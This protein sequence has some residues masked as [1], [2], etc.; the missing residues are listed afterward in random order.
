VGDLL[1]AYKKF[2]PKARLMK[3][4]KG[5]S[6]IIPPLS[7]ADNFSLCIRLPVLGAALYCSTDNDSDAD[8]M[9]TDE[10]MEVIAN[11]M[12]AGLTE[13][14]LSNDY[15]TRARSAAASCVHATITL[16]RARGQGCPVIPLVTNVINPAIAS[17]IDMVSVKDC[18]N[19]LALVVSHRL[20]GT[21]L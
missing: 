19:L 6:N 16:G 18:L 9:E 15:D 13:Y 3:L 8:T 10:S 12:L 20:C 14:V 5:V 11:S 2:V 17:A 1:P 7:E 4:L 21:F